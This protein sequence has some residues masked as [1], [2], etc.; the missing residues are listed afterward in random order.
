MIIACCPNILKF[1]IEKIQF[2]PE[3]IEPLIDFIRN[4]YEFVSVD[5]VSKSFRDEDEKKF[6]EAAKAGKINYILTIRIINAQSS[7]VLL[8]MISFLRV[9]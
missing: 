5:P 8:R 2:K 1:Y 6:Y 4:K 7:S 3:W 9:C